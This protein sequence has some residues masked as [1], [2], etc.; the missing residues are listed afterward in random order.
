MMKSG[1]KDGADLKGHHPSVEEG[2]VNRTVCFSWEQCD[3]ETKRT[4]KIK[5]CG[6]FFVYWLKP[7]HCC[8]KVYCTDPQ[9]STTEEASES[10]TGEPPQLPSSVPAGDTSTGE[11]HSKSST[12]GP[13]RETSS[14][15]EMET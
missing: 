2:E 15:Q 5:N 11:G 4:I 1:Q 10:L 13:I 3:C 9:T 14:P 8:N 6:D 7:T 12:T